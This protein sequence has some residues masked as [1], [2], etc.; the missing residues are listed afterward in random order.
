MD[1]PQGV[2]SCELFPQFIPDLFCGQPLLVVGKY[3][4]DWPQ[5]AQL[6]GVLPTGEGAPAAGPEAECARPSE[7]RAPCQVSCQ[8]ASSA[9]GVPMGRPRPKLNPPLSPGPLRPSEYL[10][11]LPKLPMGALP[12]DQLFGKGRLDLWVAQAWMD[13]DPP[14]LVQKIVALSVASGEGRASP[15]CT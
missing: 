3:E 11:P 14:E 7:A 15:Q 12:V 5:D 6:R 9:P 8:G 10:Q 2:S 4:G 13:G 1:H